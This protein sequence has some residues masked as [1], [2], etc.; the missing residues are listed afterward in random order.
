M[1]K[2]EITFAVILAALLSLFFLI[3]N[4]TSSGSLNIYPNFLPILAFPVVLGIELGL[5]A[6]RNPRLAFREAF[7]LGEWTVFYA[8]FLFA[9]VALIFSYFY[10]PSRGELLVGV[11]ALIT[12]LSTWL[13][14]TVFVL[15]CAFVIRMT[16]G[17]RQAA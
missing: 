15:L 17:K 2:H 3:G 14:G 13:I 8:A 12:I 16:A 11:S 5:A 1:G 10:F 7:R 6:R 9:A 4:P